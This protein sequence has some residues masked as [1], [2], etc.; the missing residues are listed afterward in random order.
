MI[1]KDEKSSLV[2]AEACLVDVL[3]VLACAVSTRDI[4]AREAIKIAIDCVESAQFDLGKIQ[5]PNN[6]KITYTN[7]PPVK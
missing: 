5:T 7:F 3:S 2:H 4:V 6:R 1:T